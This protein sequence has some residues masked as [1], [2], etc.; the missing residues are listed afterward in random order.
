MSIED[1][2]KKIAVA[3]DLSESEPQIADTHISEALVAITDETGYPN[4]KLKLFSAIYGTLV[5]KKKMPSS[6]VKVNES[7]QALN[8]FVIAQGYDLTN[9]VN[10]IDWPDGI[11]VNWV[12]LCER[13]GYDTNGWIISSYISL[14]EGD[15]VGFRRL[16]SLLEGDFRTY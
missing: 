5:W 14:T 3:F 10:S 4:D 11:P 13:C 1:T 15:F 16:E 7:V 2:Y 8:D 12:I 9:F 6:D